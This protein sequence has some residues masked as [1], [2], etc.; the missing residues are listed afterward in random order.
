MVGR[1]AEKRGCNIP[2]GPL[3][4]IRR[5]WTQFPRRLAD[6]VSYF[7]LFALPTGNCGHGKVSGLFLV[8]MNSNSYRLVLQQELL[9][10]FGEEM[11]CSNINSD[12][13]FIPEIFRFMLNINNSS[14]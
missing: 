13:T 3:F 11:K 5:A 9:R 8:H 6:F 4:R 2:P 14:E 7:T 10:E 12:F 1:N